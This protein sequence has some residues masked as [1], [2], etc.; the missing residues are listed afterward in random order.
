MHAIIVL[1]MRKILSYFV[2]SVFLTLTLFF[3]VTQIH[4]DE[5]EDI[6]KQLNDLNASLTQSKAATAP[7]ESQLVSMQKQIAGIKQQVA[8]ID[9]DVAKKKQEIDSGYKNLEKQQL[10]LSSTVRNYYIKT[11]YNTGLLTFFSAGD[12]S[13]ITKA[14]TYQKITT[15][16]DKVMITNIALSIQDLQTK[17]EQLEDEQKRLV[18]IKASLDEQSAKLDTVVQGAKDYQ[19]KLSTQIAQLS[20]KQQ[21]LIAQ[22][23]ASLNLP[24]SAYTTLGG[25]SSDL[26]N[27][28]DPGF[29][30]GFGFFTFGVPHRVGL[31]QYGA[32]GRAEAGQGYSDILKAYFNADVTSGYNTGINIHV[33]GTNEYGQSFDDNWNIEEYVKHIYEIPSSW[34]PEALKAQAIAARSYALAVT[35]DGASTICPSQSCQVVK[36]ELNA[37]SWVDAVNATSGVV[38]TSG[39]KPVQAWFSSTA[40]GYEFSSAAVWGSDRPWTKNALDA[41]GGVSSFADLKNNAYDKQSPWFYCDWGGRSAYGGTA[42]LKSEEVADIANVAKLAQISNQSSEV[43]KHLFQL[44]KPNSDGNWDEAKVRQELQSRGG[45][46]LTSIS[47]VDVSADFGSGKAT[48]ISFNGGA[49]SFP[50]DFFKSYFNL[51]A[52]AN[53]NIV[54]PL[55]NV[56]KK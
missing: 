18:V 42:W 9:A 11:Y 21:S 19:N 15:D 13:D 22:K 10:I 7:L 4:S 8:G 41:T 2:C 43:T 34:H 53:I 14:L 1:F 51:R 17:K 28:K 45:T 12:A 44:D 23:Q 54:G 39:G 5:L 32:K 52:P 26:T 40:G 31:S 56:E 29:S 55:Y 6:Q 49:M 38:I 36:K 33:T 47:S 37:Q 16:Q 25:C 24:T 50:A 27:G 48:T 20:A 30:P 35:S 46:P 3:N